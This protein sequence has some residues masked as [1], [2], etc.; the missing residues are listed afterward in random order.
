MADCLAGVWA[1]HAATTKD[2]NGKTFIKTLTQADIAARC[3]R[4]RPSGTTGSRS[5]PR[6]GQPGHLDPR[7]VGRSGS[8]GSTPVTETGDLRNCDTFAATSL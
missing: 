6:P 1:N 4:P 3:R 8:A 7:L 2:A 5:R